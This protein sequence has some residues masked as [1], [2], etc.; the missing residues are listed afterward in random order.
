MHFIPHKKKRKYCKCSAFASS[1]LLHLFFNS[2]SVSFVEGG[3]KNISCLRAQGTQAMPLSLIADKHSYILTNIHLISLGLILKPT[4]E[5]PE[6]AHRPKNGSSILNRQ[7][8]NYSCPWFSF[9]HELVI[10]L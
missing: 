3:H 8:I 6:Q 10:L 7:S 5:K 9:T 2:N 4:P 1:A